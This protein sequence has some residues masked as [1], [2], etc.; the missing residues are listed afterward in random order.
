MNTI[1]YSCV[2][3]SHTPQNGCET[4][5]YTLVCSEKHC[6]AVSYHTI[7][8]MTIPKH[9]VQILTQ[10]LYIKLD[11]MGDQAVILG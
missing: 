5:P 3:T 10:L 1:E 9:Y 2:E 7:V 4:V 8:L 6:T 11:V